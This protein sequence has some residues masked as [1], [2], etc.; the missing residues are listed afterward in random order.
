MRVPFRAPTRRSVGLH[1]LLLSPQFLFLRLRRR[2]PTHLPKTFLFLLL[3]PTRTLLRSFSPTQL[4]FSARSSVV[5]R[6]TARTT[7]TRKDWLCTST[8]STRQRR[9]TQH[10]QTCSWTTGTKRAKPA[11][12][13]SRRSTRVGHQ[14]FCAHGSTA[15]LQ[16]PAGS[17]RPSLAL[18][19]S[20]RVSHN[21]PEKR[22][23]TDPRCLLW[24]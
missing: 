20:L 16:T 9:V 10:S 21:P 3:L 18:C 13:C 7:E 24:S 4:H 1:P 14:W 8:R 17:G 6:A 23:Q 22:N 5:R 11:C 15:L 2:H 19:R 12:T